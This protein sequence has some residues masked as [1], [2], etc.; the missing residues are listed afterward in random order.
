VPYGAGPEG[1][2]QYMP[3]AVT[4]PLGQ[5]PD[6]SRSRPLMPKLSSEIVPVTEADPVGTT[7]AVVSQLGSRSAESFGRG[8]VLLIFLRASRVALSSAPMSNDRHSR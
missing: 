5:L 3:V 2:P 7:L 1:V 8:T 4:R 6:A